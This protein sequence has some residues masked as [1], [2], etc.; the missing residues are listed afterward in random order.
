MAGEVKR[1]RVLDL[2]FAI[3]EDRKAY[4][5]R[6][7]KAAKIVPYRGETIDCIVR[8]LSATG[9]CLVIESGIDIASRFCLLFESDK[10]TKHCQVIWRSGNKIG[11]AFD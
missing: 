1:S 6:T 4:R 3:Y 10:T 8:D 2:I 11:I 5:R 7:L 9:A